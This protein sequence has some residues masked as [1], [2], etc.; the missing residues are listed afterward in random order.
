[1]Q[2]TMP[3]HWLLRIGDGEHFKNS[4]TKSIWGV[5]SKNK[6]D[7]T[8]DNV[9]VKNFLD[10]VKSGDILWFILGKSHGKVAAVATFTHHCKRELGP[11]LAITLTNEEL[12]WTKQNGTWDTEVHYKD[13]YNVSKCDLLTHIL[14]P[15]V[16]REYNEKC[17]VN[18]PN[19]YPY[20]VRYACVTQNM[21]D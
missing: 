3:N 20:I 18:L 9:V 17:V 7:I 5:N 12:G 10:K 8:K 21:M 11:L 15:M 2:S 4:S 1:M 14:S 6:E 16:V 19:E 13:L